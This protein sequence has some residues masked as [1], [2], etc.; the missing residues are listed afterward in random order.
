MGQKREASRFGVYRRTQ[1]DIVFVSNHR[2]EGGAKHFAACFQACAP[3]H[4]SYVV[5]PPH[6]ALSERE[7]QG[8]IRAAVARLFART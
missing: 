2:T 7:P 1:A 8:G 6:G 3:V 4:V 5:D